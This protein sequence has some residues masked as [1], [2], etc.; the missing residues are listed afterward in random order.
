MINKFQENTEK[1]LIKKSVKDM[2]EK[3][4]KETEILKK[5]QTEILIVNGTINQIKYKIECLIE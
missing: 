1:Q 4:N 2:I 3:F 5:N